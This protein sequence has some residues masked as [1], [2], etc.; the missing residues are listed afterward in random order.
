MLVS[1][2]I[3]NN[4]KI[5]ITADTAAAS[6]TFSSILLLSLYRF[7]LVELSRI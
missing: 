7:Y 3:P 4:P 5:I 1:P 2:Y 6:A